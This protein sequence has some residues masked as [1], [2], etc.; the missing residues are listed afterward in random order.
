MQTKY[1]APKVISHFQ[2]I[3]A[4]KVNAKKNRENII[5]H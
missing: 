3:Y 1:K 5:H 2:V 4:I